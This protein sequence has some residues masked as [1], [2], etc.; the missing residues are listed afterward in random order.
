MANLGKVGLDSGQRKASGMQLATS[1]CIGSD[2]REET[3]R[4]RVGTQGTFGPT[5]PARVS[6]WNS[7]RDDAVPGQEL[8]APVSRCWAALAPPAVEQR[9]GARRGWRARRAGPLTPLEARG[10]IGFG[11]CRRL[12]Q[13]WPPVLGGGVGGAR[14]CGGLAVTAPP[15]YLRVCRWVSECVCACRRSG[16]GGY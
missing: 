7:R 10:R 5:T 8:V 9:R 11:A 13:K 14:L 6:S 12:G 16:I 3:R 2:T 1:G 15:Q 4:R